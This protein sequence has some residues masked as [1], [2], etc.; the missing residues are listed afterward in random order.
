MRR[1]SAIA[2][3]LAFNA[4]A[5]S[6]HAELTMPQIGWRAELN[7]QFHNVGGAVTIVDDDTVRVD[8]F[9]YDGGGPLVYFYLGASDSYNSFLTGLSIGPLLTGE[10][11]GSQAPLVID[12]P[13]GQTLEGM[14][15][16]SVWCAEF[17][18]NFGSGTFAAPPPVP[19]DYNSDG[20]VNAAD[21]TVW[22][23]TLGSTTDLSANGDNDGA[24]QGLIDQ[25]D[26][27]FWKTHFVSTSAG[28]G[29]VQ[30]TAAVPEPGS[31]ALLVVA[32][33]GMAVLV[34]SRGW[35]VRRTQRPRLRFAARI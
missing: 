19:G 6:A 23:N 24:S 4:L 33:A 22:R 20:V 12:L 31:K 15:A 1:I 25:A 32:F 34:A 30:T 7:G 3:I 26:Y 16:I 11:D 5:G 14:N 18:V 27:E 21:Y 10:F 17:N 28:L 35:R 29:S 13:S 2:V 9:T 8:D